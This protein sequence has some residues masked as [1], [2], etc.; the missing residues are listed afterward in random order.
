MLAL[1]VLVLNGPKDSI[2]LY[3]FPMTIQI[4]KGVQLM[5]AAVAQLLVCSGGRVCKQ[6]GSICGRYDLVTHF[7][8]CF[9][10][11]FCGNSCSPQS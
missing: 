3:L 7:D 11:I 6:R 10:Q 2:D 9:L 5:L 1:L 8:S 4:A